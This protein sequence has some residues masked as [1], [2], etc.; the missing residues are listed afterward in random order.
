[1][2]DVRSAPS[3]VVGIDGSRAAIQAAVWAVTEAV[4]RDIP[5]RLVYVR[6]PADLAGVASDHIQSSSARAALYD[7][8]Q[9]VEATGEPVKVETEIV[10][11]DPLAKLTE[12]SWSAAMVCV[13]S[14]GIKS[15]CHD[16][17]SVAAA[18][19]GLAQCP[20]AVIRRPVCRPAGPEAGSIVVEVDNGLVLRHAFEEAR[21]RGAPLRVVAPYRAEAPDDTA[22]RKRLVHAH[23]NRRVVGWQ[24]R[25][26]DVEV[27]PVAVR[28]SVCD[29]LANNG[30]SLQLF[31]A[32]AQR[33]RCD[34]GMPRSVE[35]SV[36]T[37]GRTNL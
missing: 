32:G 20:V 29:Y 3:V 35:F 16:G 28:G 22:D 18:L 2:H 14:V 8:Q 12:E 13:G 34:L 17:R 15:T 1:M 33:G 24:R 19:P 31:V 9:A 21:L 4:S 27:E 26:P 7:A 36:L 11:G 30:K 37:V 6:D 23:L 5:L 25:Y 10:S